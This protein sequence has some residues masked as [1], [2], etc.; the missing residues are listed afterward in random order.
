VTATGW[1]DNTGAPLPLTS[2][3]A[4]AD[5]VAA[6]RAHITARPKVT[7]KDGPQWHH[8]APLEGLLAELAKES[9]A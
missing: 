3:A 8:A 2:L 4:V 9:D 6:I 5:V 1:L 7:D